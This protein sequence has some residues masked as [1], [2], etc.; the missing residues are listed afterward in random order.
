MRDRLG[1]PT[2]SGCVH[3]HKY[4]EKN[5][6]LGD[7]PACTTIQTLCLRAKGFIMREDQLR[8][9][10][11]YKG[12][13]GNTFMLFRKY[14]PNEVCFKRQDGNLHYGREFI[15]FRNG[16]RIITLTEA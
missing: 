13:T 11:M 15:E 14:D 6:T 5:Q 3:H 10:A 4:A 16:K 8:V 12:A 1:L 2:V 7:K 9:N